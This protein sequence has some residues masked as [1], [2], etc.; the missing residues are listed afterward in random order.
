MTW[1]W[2]AVPAPGMAILDLAS[3]RT[4]GF[5]LLAAE[6]RCTPKIFV[7]NNAEEAWQPDPEAE[8]QWHLPAAGSREAHAPGGNVQSPW[9]TILDL[10][11]STTRIASVLCSS[12]SV[13]QTQD[14]GGQLGTRGDP[15]RCS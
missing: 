6:D 2:T 10:A 1:T 3:G 15:G 13:Y 9:R 14:A 12:G 5:F 7:G 4:G 8:R 11:V